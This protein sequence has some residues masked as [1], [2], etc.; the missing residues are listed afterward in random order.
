MRLVV[1]IFKQAPS[2]SLVARLLVYLLSLSE[3]VLVVI[4]DP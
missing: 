1:A 3:P 2:Y 4:K